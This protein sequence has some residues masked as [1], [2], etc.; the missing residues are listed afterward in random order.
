MSI[1]QSTN[2]RDIDRLEIDRRGLEKDRQTDSNEKSGI[3]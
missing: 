2:T 1:K 3:P